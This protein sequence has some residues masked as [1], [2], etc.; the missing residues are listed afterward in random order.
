MIISRSF[1][2]TNTNRERETAP[3]LM[4]KGVVYTVITCGK[5]TLHTPHYNP[6]WDYI[7]F[8]DDEKILK[9]NKNEINV[10]LCYVRKTESI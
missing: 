9:N 1:L 7:C 2:K 6:D 8:T 10:K 4:K 5:N 3:I